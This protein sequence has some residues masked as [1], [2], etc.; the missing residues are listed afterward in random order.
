MLKPVLRK[1]HKWTFVIFGLFMLLWVVTGIIMAVPIQSAEPEVDH[2]PDPVDFSR[3]KVSPAE[4]I[5]RLD[6]NPD[7]VNTVQLYRIQGR[8]VYAV[9]DENWKNHLLDAVSGERF[10]FT[11]ETA[12]SIARRAFSID[13][14]VAENR[15]L[16]AHTMTYPWGPLP[17]YRLSFEAD[18]SVYYY[19]NPENGHIDRSSFMSRFNA[20]AGFLHDLGPASVITGRENAKK[21]LLILTGAFSLVGVL[22][23]FYI[24]FPLTRRKKQAG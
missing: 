6:L 13:H 1:I 16:E 22:A 5:Q 3:A 15:L 11:P 2:L 23:G 24:M 17:V 8:I 21:L 19:V 12:E 20:A 14:P 10:S 7:K 9:K 4:A 18:P